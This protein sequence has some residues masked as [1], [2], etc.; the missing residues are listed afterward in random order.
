[1]VNEHGVK[2][3]VYEQ[4]IAV[5]L[6]QVTVEEARKDAVRYIQSQSDKDGCEVRYIDDV[7]GK[8]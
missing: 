4:I 6:S 1:M 3:V 2:I 8:L 5:V 7:I